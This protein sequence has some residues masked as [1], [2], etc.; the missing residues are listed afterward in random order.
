MFGE[1]NLFFLINVSL[2]IVCTASVIFWATLYKFSTH[3][4]VCFKYFKFSLGLVGYLVKET[5]FF[6]INVSLTVYVIFGATL[7][8][9]IGR[10]FVAVGRAARFR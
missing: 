3:R 7:Y 1:K 10:M 4:H 2:T 5:Y 8:I 6:L 9:K